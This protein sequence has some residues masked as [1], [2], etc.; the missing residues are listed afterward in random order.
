MG[1]PRVWEK[2]QEKMKSVG[3]KS[4]TVRRKVAAWAKDVGLQTNLTKMN[5]YVHVDEITALLTVFWFLFSQ[6]LLQSF[7]FFSLA[8]DCRSTLNGSCASSKQFACH[9]ARLVLTVG[10]LWSLYNKSKHADPLWVSSLF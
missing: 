6:A 9:T 10:L 3:A 4:S 5:Q 1:V 7:V 2:M 8:S